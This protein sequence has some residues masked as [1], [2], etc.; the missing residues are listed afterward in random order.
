MLA[1][2]AACASVLSLGHRAPRVA[3]SLAVAI[4]AG[5][6]SLAWAQEDGVELAAQQEP[7]PATAVPEIPETFVP[8]RA[9]VFPANPLPADVAVTPTRTYKTAERDCRDYEQTVIVD[10]REEIIHGTACR[11]PDG[12]W[13]AL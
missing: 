7:A 6:F 9:G 11:E 13:R 3:L 8:G 4:S 12:T 1:V 5:T 10:G 2:R